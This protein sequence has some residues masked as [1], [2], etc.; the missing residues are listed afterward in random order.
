M[1]TVRR[2]V[3]VVSSGTLYV[4]SVV[5]DN[6]PSIFGTTMFRD[7]KIVRCKSLYIDNNVIMIQLN[8]NFHGEILEYETLIYHTGKE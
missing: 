3:A 4:N 8:D 5:H 7:M 6:Y 1:S 2:P